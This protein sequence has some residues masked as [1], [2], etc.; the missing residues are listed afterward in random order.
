MKG[1]ISWSIKIIWNLE[2]N[3]LK[4]KYSI[5][6]YVCVCV[7]GC[8]WEPCRIS[9][10]RIK[11]KYCL[12]DFFLFTHKK[13]CELKARA[14]KQRLN[15][16][17]IQMRDGHYCFYFYLRSIENAFE[18]KRCLIVS[19]IQTRMKNPTHCSSDWIK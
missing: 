3:L 8:L 6:I 5:Y 10:F 17:T 19:K 11:E 12:F 15:I 16:I 4:Q 2:Q 18:K 9:I 14:W 13:R 1:W 7:C